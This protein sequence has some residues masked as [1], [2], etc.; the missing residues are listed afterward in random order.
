MMLPSGGSQS[1]NN[2]E[3][4]MNGKLARVALACALALPAV[5][6]AQQGPEFGRYEYYAK[7]ASCHGIA[8]KGDGPVAKALTKAPSDLT[9]Y[10]KRNGGVFPTQ[11]AWQAIDGRPVEIAAHGTREMPV[12]GT[13]FR[14][15]TLRPADRLRP[16]DPSPEW[17]V[18][19][20]IG[21]LID[22]LASIQ[23]K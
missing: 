17:H 14:R 6:L 12:W 16:G 19:A 8:G 15:E 9:T 23:A 18:A 7:C 13:E 5:A 11:L 10:A 4:V 1:G 20:R 21:A 22:Y 3:A 2:K